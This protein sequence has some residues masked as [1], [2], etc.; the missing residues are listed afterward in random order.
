M[1][2]ERARTADADILLSSNCC[3]SSHQGCSRRHFLNLIGAFGVGAALP[4]SR[5]FAQLAPPDAAAKTK[6]ID[7]HHHILPPIYIQHMRAEIIAISDVDPAPLLSWTP[8]RALEQMDRYGIATAVTSLALPGVWLGNPLA[9][10]KLTRACNEYGAQMVRDHPGR[11]GLLAALPLPDQDGS[12]AELAY[13]LDTL[14]ADGICLLTSYGDRWPGDPAFSLVFEELNRRKAVVYIHPTVP[15]CCTNLIPGVPPAATEFLFDTTRAIT[16]LLVNG[17]FS[18]F[19]DIRFMF[20]HSGGTMPVLAR[21]INAFFE[22]HKDLTAQVPNGVLYELKK[23]HYDIA[24]A[25]N[26][27]SLSAL[28]NLVPKSQILFGSD[29]PYVPIR[30]TI[31]G[32][33][34]FGLS[35]SDLRA[36]NSGN[37]ME[38][39]PRLKRLA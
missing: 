13:A 6:R 14:K 37:A 2:P 36:I 28:I 11:F 27:S 31:E 18:R 35:T 22:R 7:V 29:F 21:R 32:L 39:F 17:T 3:G 8:A 5:W 15:T 23:L 30:V 19:P 20:A 10:R 33:D 4:P 12:L 1:K 9:S 34:H 25:S 26:P 16:S 38:L 24:N